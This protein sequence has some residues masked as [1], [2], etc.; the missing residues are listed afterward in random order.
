MTLLQDLRKA[1][2]ELHDMEHFGPDEDCPSMEVFD[3][4]IVAKWE[5]VE[6]LE[7]VRWVIAQEGMF[8]WKGKL[9]HHTFIVNL[10]LIIILGSLKCGTL[11]HAMARKESTG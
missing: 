3:R 8:E 6:T 11:R 9:L 4:M 5:Q 1:E 2:S 10:S 7:D